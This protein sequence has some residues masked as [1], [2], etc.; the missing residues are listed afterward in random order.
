[1]IAKKTNI[2]LFFQ[3]RVQM[4]LDRNQVIK[5]YATRLVN[6]LVPKQFGDEFAQS[7]VHDLLN[8][9]RGAVGSKLIQQRQ[10]EL[11]QLTAHYKLYFLNHGLR[12]EWT[13]FE[14]VWDQ[15]SQVK[16]VEQLHS[17]LM[18]FNALQKESENE[19]RHRSSNSITPESFH[20]MPRR[21]NSRLSDHSYSNNLILPSSTLFNHSLPHREPID[22]HATLDQITQPYYE[23]MPEK[24]ILTY[25][26]YTLLGLDSKLLS[27]HSNREIDLPNALSNSYSALLSNVLE[28]GLL[29]RNCKGIIE[30][31]KGKLG[32][33]IKMAFLVVME[34]QLNLYANHVNTLFINQ[35]RSLIFVYNSIFP[36]ILTL[37]PLYMLIMKLES[38]SGF[39]LLTQVYEL[40]KYQDHRIRDLA[41]MIFHHIS[42]PYYEIIENWIINGELMDNDTGND[43]FFIRFRVDAPNFNDIIEHIP[44]KLPFF[45]DKQTSYKMFQIGK[46][47]IF[48][49]KI[50][51]ELRWVNNYI[52]KYSHIIFQQHRGL[53]SMSTNTFQE[54][55]EMQYTE[56]LNY[57]T[58]V[59]QGSKNELFQ[60]LQNF[61][62]FYL[63]QNNEFIDLIISKGARI[64]NEPSSNISLNY[65]SKLLGESIGESAL[66]HNLYAHRLDARILDPI[67]GN[68]GWEVFT[69]EYRIDD[70]PIYTILEGLIM[71]YLKIFNFLWRM[72]HLHYLLIQNSVESAN[73]RRLEFNKI[74]RKYNKVRRNKTLGVSDTKV[75]W[76]AKTFNT[77]SL[78]RNNFIKFLNSLL[79]YLVFDVVETLFDQHIVNK[80]FTRK[81]KVEHDEEFGFKNSLLNLLH[82]LNPSFTQLLQS[83][84]MGSTSTI[85]H[86]MNELTFDELVKAHNDYLDSIINHK[87]INENSV[88]KHT[89]RTIISQIYQLLEVIFNFIKGSEEYNNLLINYILVLNI[90]ENDV[91]SD[92]ID[93]LQDI[94]TQLQV[95]MNMIYKDIYLLQYKTLLGDFVRD[96]KSDFDL[97]DLSYSFAYS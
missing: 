25:L 20:D 22:N 8:N 14:R 65:L 42:A 55:I 48:L 87:L 64:L 63:T 57:F 27:F 89:Q 40:T 17:Y 83:N 15:L 78:I 96:L 66:R 72:R 93:D 84:T 71:Q 11:N 6:S 44:E 67:H 81:F 47:I 82:T 69:I 88:G 50:C 90:D 1:M 77:V 70:L 95:L 33:S 91:G 51:K 24:E 59:V 9:A 30:T 86:N 3:L 68:I 32:S 94:E 92:P 21:A 18:F 2:G 29:Y 79:G 58:I 23:T 62:R 7:F 41:L 46:M 73:L 10:F 74:M 13:A 4:S 54:L 75:V 31:N 37:R 80:F 36:W 34:S 35:P 97:K 61:K 56:L 16:S 53:Q 76:I 45:C 19:D 52:N 26:P 43:E 28:C 60:H 39:Q 85:S 12:Q 38:L 49:T 5:V